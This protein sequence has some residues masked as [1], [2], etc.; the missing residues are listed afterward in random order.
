[1]LRRAVALGI[2]MNSKNCP[3]SLVLF[4]RLLPPKPA[5]NPALIW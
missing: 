3:N 4:D 2:S 5:T 1:M